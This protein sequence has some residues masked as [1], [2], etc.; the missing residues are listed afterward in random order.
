[1]EATHIIKPFLGA[2]PYIEKVS[3]D[4]ARPFFYVRTNKLGQLI[5]DDFNRTSPVSISTDL[6]AVTEQ[7]AVDKWN[8]LFTK[9]V[10]V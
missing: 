10:E 9:K 5:G 1:M 7:E 6:F 8:S 4:D 3:P 2:N